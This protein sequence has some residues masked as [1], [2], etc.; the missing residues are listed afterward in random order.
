MILKVKPYK[1]PHF[2]RLIKY[3]LDKKE[4]LF[5]KEGKPFLI[6]HNLKGQG[7]AQWV[8]EFKKNEGFRLRK[9]KNQNYL[10]HE[11]LSF[12][13][14]DNVSIEQMEEMTREYINQRNPK[15]M[16]LA[17]GHFDKQ[18]HVHLCTPAIE[19]R[20]G[21]TMRMSKAQFQKLKENIQHYQEEKFPH[22]SKSIVDY[23]VR[24]GSA[25]DKELQM[26]RRTG[27]E[28][29][30]GQLIGML[31]TC[32]KKAN[33]KEAFF[34]LLEECGLKVYSRGGKIS[35]V[36]FANKKFRLKRIG[37]TEERLNELDTSLDRGK[38]LK[39][40]RGRK[41]RNIERNI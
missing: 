18:P 21:K 10:T 37:F 14:H 24:K 26:K 28:S 27:R 22:L 38:E 39:E 2:E 31:K 13:Q 35:G 1:R 7:I 11:I 30:K 20:T 33:S 6:T 12:H 8:Q 34:Q 41:G 15:G 32:Y 9:R 25:G 5:S 17:V 40:T 23:K 4:K 29:Q 19:F 16:Y 36:H 3:M